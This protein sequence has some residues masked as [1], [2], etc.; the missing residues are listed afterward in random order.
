MKQTRCDFKQATNNNQ[1]QSKRQWIKQYLHAI[2][3]EIVGLIFE[4]P[5]IQVQFVLW[6]DRSIQT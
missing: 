1:T 2:A 3:S 5:D 4:Q 6:P